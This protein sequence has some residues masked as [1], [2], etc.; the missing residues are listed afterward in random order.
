MRIFPTLESGDGVDRRSTKSR[1]QPQEENN[2]D[3]EPE[4]E[5]KHPPVGGKGKARRVVGWIDEAKHKRCRPRRKECPKNGG[6]ES[7]QRT[8]REDELDKTTAAGSDR[9]S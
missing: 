5:E 3:N 8:L 9:D 7:Q 2:E 1:K 4:A 6:Q